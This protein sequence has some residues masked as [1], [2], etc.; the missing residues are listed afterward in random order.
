MASQVTTGNGE[1]LA[2]AHKLEAQL[3]RKR[4]L[5]IC[6]H[7]GLN[8]AGLTVALVARVSLLRESGQMSAADAAQLL[9]TFSSGVGALEFA[10]NPLAGKLSDTYGRKPFL[11]Q[12]PLV[13]VILKTLVVLR[14]STLTI[15]I[16]RISGACTT[17]GGSTSCSAA[18]ADILSDTKELSQAYSMLGT[19][20]GLG[21]IIGPMLGAYAIGRSGNP[22]RA[23]A[24]GAVLSGLQLALVSSQIEEP[25]RPE[26][27]KP[28]PG[29]E[30]LAAINPLTVTKLF[31]NGP[32]V[33]TLVSVASIQCFCE[34]K[35]ISD[36]N[37]Y[38][39]LN[40]A[41]FTDAKRSLYL[42][43]L[44]IVMTASGVIG[45]K[46]VDWFGM[47]GHTTFQNL[48]SILGFS[49]MGSTVSEPV[50]FGSLFFYAFG[51]ER[52]SAMSSLALKAAEQAGMGK[53]EF[54][55]AFANLRAIVV[56]LAPLVYA[57]V[58]GKCL[59]RKAWAG[60]P[61]YVAAM[62]ALI[63]EL[64]HRTLTNS[65]LEFK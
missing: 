12:A 31:M 51:M 14:P 16:E 55:A 2:T 17:I 37:V 19:A 7:M 24:A 11:M 40:E 65:Q 64:L 28:P 60:R 44:G 22:R 1:E 62:M 36:L 25:L 47:R 43:S 56:G 27:R 20:A 34:G 23:F 57:R 42:T 4:V 59:E 53:G 13:S 15:A 39:L 48:A 38:Y 41:K 46:T 33:A 8:V 18:L 3:L 52:R 49:I 45:R 26:N 32:V 30:L 5:R 54:S 50:I 61:Y 6:A 21:V 35:A 10:L 63:S 58:Y 29:K 9:A